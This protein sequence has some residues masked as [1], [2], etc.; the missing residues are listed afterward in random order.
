[1]RCPI[2]KGN[3][4]NPYSSGHRAIDIGWNK[5]GIVDPLIYSPLRGIVQYSLYDPDSGNT[6]MIRHDYSVTHFLVTVYY[7]LKSRSVVKGQLVNE[8]QI[9]GIGGTTGSWSTGNHLHFET[10]LIPISILDVNFSLRSRYAFDPR[11]MI[12]TNNIEGEGIHMIQLTDSYRIASTDK[13]DLNVR[14]APSL[15]AP[16]LGQCI[17][18]KKY[19]CLGITNEI[20]GYVWA[21]VV[22]DDQVVYVA[23]KYLV[24]SDPLMIDSTMTDGC[25]TV[26]VSTNG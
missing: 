11:A 21:K 25:L 4:T 2:D 6:I 5:Y 20:D 24:L 23:L 16:I 22:K 3:L 17:K 1:M 13:S 8:G 15:Q 19:T 14:L 7:H 18:D 9:I 26:R 12:S 10:W